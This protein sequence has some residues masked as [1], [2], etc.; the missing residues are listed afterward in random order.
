MRG[1]YEQGYEAAK[2]DVL[3]IL[4]SHIDAEWRRDAERLVCA[5]VVAQKLTTILTLVLNWRPL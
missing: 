1:T 5:Q 3:N 4:Q 2:Q